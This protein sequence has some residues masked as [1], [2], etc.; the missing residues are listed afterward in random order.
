VFNP[1]IFGGTFG[2]S[3]TDEGYT[4]LGLSVIIL[5]G[6]SIDITSTPLNEKA[7]GASIRGLITIVFTS[8]NKLVSRFKGLTTVHPEG[9]DT[10]YTSPTC[11]VKGCK[12]ACI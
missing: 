10:P 3:V 2:G 9:I 5:C 11:I 8:N 1:A 7:R 6:S 12:Y 4:N